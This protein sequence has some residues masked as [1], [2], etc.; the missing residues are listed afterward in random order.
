ME[1][2]YKNL[3]LLIEKKGLEKD[4]IK[5]HKSVNEIFHDIEGEF[6][7]N[8]H[9]NMW[10]SLPVIF[11]IISEEITRQIPEINN[12]KLKMLD[13]GSGTGLSTELFLKTEI[14]VKIEQITLLDSSLTMI[15]KSKERAIN[16]NVDNIEF[17]KGYIDEL[18]GQF[19]II[20][21]SSLLHHIP[22]LTA[23]FAKINELQNKGGLFVHLQDPNT[24]AIVSEIY[25]KRKSRFK[26]S[27]L[28]QKQNNSKI[29]FGKKIV[30]I[31][32]KIKRRL[33]GADYINRVNKELKRQKIIRKKLTATEIWSVTDIHVENLPYSTGAG[34]SLKMIEH[35][36]PQYK[37]L[38]LFS[39]AFFGA[40]SYELPESFQK[41]E[42]RLLEARDGY[43][44]NMAGI[45]LKSDGI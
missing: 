14:G 12:R 19:D 11:D 22:D 10:N 29:A 2:A 8:F 41:E 16:W 21:C 27:L 18:S 25:K 9:A 33:L 31:L 13:I 23:F 42:Q 5:F 35:C 43:G 32:Y 20:L 3:K 15:E 7:D 6:Y 4:P 24:E 17:V 26:K 28:E 30:L 45:W 37:N 36:L 40:L 44:R 34:I 39:Y 38:Y 1:D